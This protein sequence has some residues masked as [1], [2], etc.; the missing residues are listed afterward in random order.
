MSLSCPIVSQ[1]CVQYQRAIH[2]CS[3]WDLSAR[4]SLLRSND[5]HRLPCRPVRAKSASSQC[6]DEPSDDLSTAFAREMA[7]RNEAQEKALEQGEAV[8]FG[9]RQLLEALQSRYGRSY[10]VSIVQRKYLGKVIIA[11][12]I[13]WKYREQVSFG[14]TEEEYMERLDGVAAALRAWGKVKQVK[15]HIAS[16]KTGPRVGKAISIILDLD[17]DTIREWFLIS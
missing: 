14:L 10:D 7:S 9:G 2:G 16:S 11:C 12:N 4:R 17:D 6:H 5:L 3:Y 15:E 1:G 13:M 8:A